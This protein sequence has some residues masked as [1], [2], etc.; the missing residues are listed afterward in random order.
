MKKNMTR[1]WNKYDLVE[2]RSVNWTK[3]L[4]LNRHPQT[5]W[6]QLKYVQCPYKEELLQ[7]KKMVNVQTDI[8]VS[9]CYGEKPSVSSFVK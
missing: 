9:S 1:L 6:K 2:L 4:V 3:Q 7:K 5:G 8:Y